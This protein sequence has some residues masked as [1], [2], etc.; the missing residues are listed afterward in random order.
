MNEGSESL[1]QRA[2]SLGVHLF[3]PCQ[4]EEKY[5]NESFKKIWDLIK[6]PKLKEYEKIVLCSTLDYFVLKPEDIDYINAHG[7][8]TPLGDLL[9]L[10]AIKTL[11]NQNL[12]ALKTLSISSTKSM[13]GHSLGAAGALEAVA[14]VMAIRT[15]KIH[16][17]I[18]LEDPEEEVK[19]LN[20]VPHK[21]KEAHIKVALN[22]SFGFGGHN[23]SMVLGE[24]R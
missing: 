23:A 9:E 7:T 2:R 10:R 20:L 8:S 18:N 16:P 21:A 5:F 13:I 12:N 15:H 14:T 24:Y 17:T 1:C 22:N 6:S 19:G 3:F 11:F 4:K